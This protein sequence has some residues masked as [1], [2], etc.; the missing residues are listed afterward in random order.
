MDSLK[1][2]PCKAFCRRVE[3][4]PHLVLWQTRVSLL[5]LANLGEWHFLAPAT[6]LSSNL[7][8][9]QADGGWGVEEER[10]GVTGVSKSDST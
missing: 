3:R 9:G 8:A 7:E 6:L 5:P 1:Q 10:G 2:R 4:T